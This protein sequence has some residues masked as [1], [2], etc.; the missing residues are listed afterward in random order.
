VKLRDTLERISLLIKVEDGGMC[1]I[2]I[3]HGVSYLN[4]SGITCHA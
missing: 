2:R 3:Q 4:T 1:K